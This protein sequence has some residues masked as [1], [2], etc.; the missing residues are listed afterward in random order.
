MAVAIAPTQ[1]ITTQKSGLAA[2][3]VYT[4]TPVEKV[5]INAGRTMTIGQLNEHLANQAKMSP[6]GT[7]AR[8]EDLRKRA[9]DIEFNSKPDENK[10]EKWGKL[11]GDR[12]NIWK[13]VQGGLLTDALTNLG[14]GQHAKRIEKQ[15]IGEKDPMK[16]L[17]TLS[18]IDPEFQV[19]FKGIEK[20]LPMKDL[21]TAVGLSKLFHVWTGDAEF[22]KVF[23]FGE[24]AELIHNLLTIATAIKLPELTDKIIGKIKDKRL[25]KKIAAQALPM[26]AQSGD[27]HT[28]QVVA[29]ELNVYAVSNMHPETVEWLLANYRTDHGGDPTEE[30]GKKFL[31][32]LNTLRANWWLTKR[33]EE[34]VYHLGMFAELSDHARIILLRD[35]VLKLPTSIS[36]MCKSKS[37][38]ELN[39]LKRPWIKLPKDVANPEDR[40]SVTV[41]STATYISASMPARAITAPEGSATKVTQLN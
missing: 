40:P 16:I 14:Y 23:G 38:V 7:K 3:D 30:E 35:K 2:A 32:L 36:F 13:D 26:A 29:E 8:L 4:G 37:F 10:M 33:G 9:W 22:M 41:V 1:F 34:T 28:V 18:T 27:M 20:A 25:K 39:A 17:A 11:W 6:K 15:I 31:E 5:P 21:D 24:E 12:K 19:A